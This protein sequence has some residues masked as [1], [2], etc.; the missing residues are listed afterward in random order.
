MSGF[1]TENVHALTEIETIAKPFK[2]LKQASRFSVTTMN[3]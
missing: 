2:V 3:Y 1:L